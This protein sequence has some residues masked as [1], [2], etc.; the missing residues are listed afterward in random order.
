MLHPLPDLKPGSTV[1]SK[2]NKD[3]LKQGKQYVIKTNTIRGYD[4]YLMLEEVEGIHNSSLFECQ[5]RDFAQMYYS[6]FNK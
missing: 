2:S 5:Y 4:I 1:I 3:Q 6:A